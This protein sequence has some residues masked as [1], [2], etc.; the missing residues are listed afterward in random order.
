MKTTTTKGLPVIISA[1]SGSGKSTIA[2][3]LIQ[4]IP[5]A[6]LS[7]SCTTR[8][9]RPGET[10][11]EHYYFFKT[12]E[13]KR[14][15][16][17]GGFLE[18]AE[19]HGHYY[20]TPL[21]R[22]KEQLEKGKDVIMTIDVQGALAVKRLFPKGV[23]IFLI[24]PSWEALK[25]RLASRD[26]DDAKSIKIRLAN[27]RKELSYL[28]HYDYLV[29]NDDLGRAVSDVGAILRAEHRRL[30]RVNKNDISILSKP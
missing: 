21:A 29:I 25:E 26:A 27:A 4:E 12:D 7:V 17:S 13:F 8:P 11:G 9:P 14:Q 22:L 3:R 6:V 23:Y 28:S 20:G 30:T 18:W 1:P 10:D 16:K 24:P 19:V 15:I 5:G 2:A